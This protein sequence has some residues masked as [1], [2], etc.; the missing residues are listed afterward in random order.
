VGGVSNGLA[1]IIFRSRYA[2]NRRTGATLASGPSAPVLT[3]DSGELIHCQ[4]AGDI[5]ALIGMGGRFLTLQHL[6]AAA[7][8]EP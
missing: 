8:G 1:L 5:L 3:S 4:E 2:M 6:I 7:H